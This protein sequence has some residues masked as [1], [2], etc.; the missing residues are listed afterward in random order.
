[1]SRSAPTACSAS[2][3]PAACVVLSPGESITLPPYCYHKFWGA[4]GKVLV[5]EV[6]AVNDDDSD[7]R[8]LEPLPRYAQIEED[9][10]ARCICYAPIIQPTIKHLGRGPR[11]RHKNTRRLALG[12]TSRFD[13][14]ADRVRAVRMLALALSGLYLFFLF[15]SA[16]FIFSMTLNCTILLIRSYGMG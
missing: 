15:A 10:A 4:E 8:F 12:T 5:G 2:C 6:S 7:N 13:C 16:R 9:E 14:T 3:R 1:M 11:D